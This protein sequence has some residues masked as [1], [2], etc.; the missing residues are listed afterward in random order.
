MIVGELAIT[1]G[2]TYIDLKSGAFRLVE[3]TPSVAQSKRGGVWNDNMLADGRR[4]VMF[5]RGN[6]VETLQLRV[7]TSTQDDT[8]RETSEFLRFG[9]VS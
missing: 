6:A 9:S 8:I 3:W 7:V 1:D 5:K 2:T 4:P